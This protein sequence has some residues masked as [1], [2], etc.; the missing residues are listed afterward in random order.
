MKA[1]S[2]TGES[3]AYI[4][5]RLADGNSL[6]RM[7]LES[8]GLRGGHLSLIADS[9]T[10]YSSFYNGGVASSKESE[11]ELA[12]AIQ[13]YLT[14]PS[15]CVILENTLAKPSDPYV[16]RSQFPLAL[17]QD[18]VFHWLGH[19]AYTSTYLQSFIKTPRYP[20]ALTGFFT[21]IQWKDQSFIK[22]SDDQLKALVNSTERIVIGAFDYEGFLIWNRA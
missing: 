3:D 13:D 4:R 1:I 14:R 10:N 11:R 5:E 19:G 12:V 6:G 2:L 21:Q 18:E 9:A 20:I 16:Q 7:A 22:L 17:Y 8:I 15:S